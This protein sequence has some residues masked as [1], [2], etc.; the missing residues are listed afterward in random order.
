MFLV[1]LQPLLF[2]CFDFSAKTAVTSS[3][4]TRGSCVN[5]TA[6]PCDSLLLS[7]SHYWFGV[8]FSYLCVQI[9]H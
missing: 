8:I 9:I 5:L 1:Y 2:V 6:A 3:H 7:S 4:S